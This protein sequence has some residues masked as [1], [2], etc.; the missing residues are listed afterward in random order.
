MQHL[1]IELGRLAVAAPQ[2]HPLAEQL[3]AVVSGQF[4]RSLVGVLDRT[5]QVGHD[6]R[7]SKGFQ[8][9]LGAVALI[10]QFTG[11]LGQALVQVFGVV[12]QPLEEL[13]GVYGLR[14]RIGHIL[15]K[16]LFVRGQLLRGGIF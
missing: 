5:I 14:H 3:R 8:D 13:G 2:A 10:F 6:D 11:P 1:G 15:R 12:L 9:G 4:N 16:L 7:L